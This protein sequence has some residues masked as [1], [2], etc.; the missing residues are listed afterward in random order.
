MDMI[1]KHGVYEDKMNKNLELSQMQGEHYMRVRLMW[2]V[3]S[4]LVLKS[5]FPECRALA[6]FSFIFPV[7]ATVLGT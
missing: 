4:Y 6:L 5:I 3:C 2:A 7:S 1:I